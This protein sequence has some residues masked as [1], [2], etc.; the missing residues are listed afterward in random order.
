M[1]V[2]LLNPPFRGLRAGSRWPHRED[3][4]KLS[5]VPFPFSMGFASALLESNDFEVKV[6][7]AVAEHLGDDEYQKRI[8]DVNSGDIIVIETSTV[9]I[10]NDVRYACELKEIG[11][12]VILVGFHVSALPFEEYPCDHIIT[13]EY[14]LSLLEL[15]KRIQ[16]GERCPRVIRGNAPD[17]LD[18]LPTPAWHLFPIEKYNESVCRYKPNFQHITSRGCPY[19][20]NFCYTA[21]IYP[22]KWRP[23]KLERVISDVRLA[24]ERY[25][26]IKEVYFDDD[27]GTVSEKRTIEL[28]KRMGEIGIPWGIMAHAMFLDYETIKTMAENNCDFIKIGI[29]SADTAI[30]RNMNKPLEINKVRGVVKLCKDFGIRVHATYTVGYIGENWKSIRKTA[31]LIRELDTESIQV[32]ICTPLVGTPFYEECLKK[33][34]LVTNDFSK[35][36][37]SKCCVV[38][39]PSLGADEI[40]KMQHY[41]LHVYFKN[42]LTIAKKA[43]YLLRQLLRSITF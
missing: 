31:K 3:L 41:L 14:E 43:G 23:F 17:P 5:T 13:G 19:R 12:K 34:W 22:H 32:S 7:D 18:I 2:F 37:G 8:S 6:I 29:E 35:F 30:L 10:N 27:T 21:V 9:S 11:A 28:S 20:C 42:K 39:Y 26:W 16:H 36:D 38:N 15:I 33:G 1:R 24:L 25:S 4:S 40:T